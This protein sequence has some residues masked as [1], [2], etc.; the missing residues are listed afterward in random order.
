ME[1]NVFSQHEQA[2]KFRAIRNQVLT[3]NIANADTPNYKAR[4]FDFGSMLRDAKG[5]SLALQGTNDGHL[6][7]SA[8]RSSKLSTSDLKYRVPHQPSLD[9]NTVETDVEQGKFAENALHYR[10]SLA[11]LDG[12][13]RTL[14]FAIRGSD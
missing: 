3:N 11:F 13:I 10:A 14:K 5:A 7:T 1:L 2:L 6:G 4:D 9:G 8:E 12:Q